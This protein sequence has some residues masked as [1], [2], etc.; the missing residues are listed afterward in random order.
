MLIVLSGLGPRVYVRSTSLDRSL[1]KVERQLLKSSFHF[2]C[3]R[4]TGRIICK[5]RHYFLCVRDLKTA[6]KQYIQVPFYLMKTEKH[7]F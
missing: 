7:F 4:D 5:H 3:W 1:V 6:V 2:L